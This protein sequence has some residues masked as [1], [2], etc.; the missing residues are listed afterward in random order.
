MNLKNSLTFLT[1]LYVAVLVWWLS[2]Y[3]SGSREGLMINI[4]GLFWTVA[5][6]LFSL[7]NVYFCIRNNKYRPSDKLNLGLLIVNLGLFIWNL[8]NTSW[9]LL[10]I[11]L[12]IDIPFPSVADSMFLLSYSFYIVGYFSILISNNSR[13]SARGT[14]SFLKVMLLILIVFSI[15][16]VPLV[17]VRSDLLLLRFCLNLLYV[18]LDVITLSLFISLCIFV[19][20]KKKFNRD[21]F[22][23]HFIVLLLSVVFELIA[24][25][26]FF[27][28][29][30][31]NSYMNG[32]VVD[33]FF[34][35]YSLVK[36]IG[37]LLFLR[38]IAPPS[39]QGTAAYGPNFLIQLPYLKQVSLNM[40]KLPH[41]IY[42]LF[43]TDKV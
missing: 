14:F 1:G 27:I 15:C 28:G 11:F 23:A 10:G 12:K 36:N 21:A 39:L 9:V 40:K 25:V 19:L 16:V 22:G 20:L 33:L 37:S 6:L 2:I 18:S 30:S 41:L 42:K 29:T 7:L 17:L 3:L 38:S 32:G 8:G 24:D 34:L 26:G 13:S 43:N 35:S 5:S 31:E 4:F